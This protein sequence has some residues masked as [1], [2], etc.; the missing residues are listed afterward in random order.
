[1]SPTPAAASQP[2]SFPV[3]YPGKCEAHTHDWCLY[4]GLFQDNVT[5]G[6]KDD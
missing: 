4:M 6:K 1:M 2:S 5:A 3:L